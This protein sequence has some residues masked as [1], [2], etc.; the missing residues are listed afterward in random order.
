MQ[1]ILLDVP[2]KDAKQDAAARGENLIGSLVAGRYCLERL[3]REASGSRTYRGADRQT[4][5]A[6]VI[7]AIAVRSLTPGGL[8][9]LEY[10][11]ALLKRAP[12]PWCAPLLHA[13]CQG[14]DF[15][16]V[17]KHI[18]GVSLAER[19]DART[20][21]ASETLAVGRA[22]LSALR[23]LHAHRV[24]HRRVRPTNIIVSEDGPLVTATLVDFGP[25][26]CVQSEGGLDR[27]VE[28]AR[29]V[30]PEQAGLID[31]DV[32]EASDLYSAGL[33]LHRCLAGESPFH[34]DS[35]G[36]ILFEQMTGSVAGLAQLGPAVPRALDEVIQR[37][38][39]KDPRDRYQSAEAVLNDL[40]AI[41]EGLRGGGADPVVVIGARDRRD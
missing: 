25:A 16:L 20:L 1:P 14:E 8:M 7:K 27:P 13:E 32:T 2:A 40:E 6:C 10:E 15:L 41:A 38:L 39:R 23:D 5:E 33:V 31:Q 21:E 35:V 22:L 9:R 19:L 26:G 28:A 3:L 29:Y 11:S 36:A 4:G 17:M 30:S 18:P 34:G 37:L 24:L 12:S